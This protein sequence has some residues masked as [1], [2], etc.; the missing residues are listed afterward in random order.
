MLLVRPLTHNLTK[1]YDLNVSLHKERYQVQCY[2]GDNMSLLKT[3]SKDTC[4]N[5]DFQIK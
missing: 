1:A 4:H 5:A 2:I 3:I